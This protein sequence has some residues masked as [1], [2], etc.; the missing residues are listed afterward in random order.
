MILSIIYLREKESLLL[1]FPSFLI[2]IHYLV[3]AQTG[4]VLYIWKHGDDQND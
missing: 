1:C 2:F 4:D 3:V